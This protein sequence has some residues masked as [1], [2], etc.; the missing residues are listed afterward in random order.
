MENQGW[1]NSYTANRERRFYNH[2]PLRSISVMPR[3]FTSARI[4]S[5][6]RSGVFRWIVGLAMFWLLAS[7]V[8][9][10]SLPDIF[11]FSKSPS[12]SQEIPDSVTLNT[13]TPAAAFQFA[14]FD[15]NL[16]PTSHPTPITPQPN[17]LSIMPTATGKTVVVSDL[18]FLSENKLVRWDHLTNFMTTLVEGVSDYSA[19]QDSRR[20]ALLREMRITANGVALYNL[21]LLDMDNK[22]IS[23]LLKGSPRLNE[24]TISPNGVWIAYQTDQKENA[25]IYAINIHA[26]DQPRQVGVCHASASVPCKI[27]GWSPDNFSLIWEDN[28]GVWISKMDK[29]QPALLTGDQIEVVDPKGQTSQVTVSFKGMNWSPNGRYILSQVITEANVCWFAVLDSYQ[30]RWTEVPG[31]FESTCP[32]RA[33]V[34]WTEDGTILVMNLTQQISAP[35]VTISDWQMVPTRPGLF[36]LMNEVELAI[37]QAPSGD[38]KLITLWPATVDENTIGFGISTINSESGIAFY[39]ADL[40]QE[41]I[42][43]ITEIPDQPSAA[44][45]AP[46]GSGILNVMT[47]TTALFIPIHE[48]GLV[49]LSTLSCNNCQIFTWAPPTPRSR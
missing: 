39:L 27:V 7:Q 34:A 32:A 25:P 44:L 22:Q 42:T 46:D 18:L 2:T 29:S 37:L 13:P 12:Q 23:N 11:Q 17:E 31:T 48:E 5:L 35:R 8:A 19:N 20:I 6:G 4:H 45:W 43:L 16:T 9:C 21:D 36:A 30:L 41:R 26:V 33:S 40:E 10:S 1:A 14:T 3:F 15:N 49:D 28:Q 38:A 47:P 24:L